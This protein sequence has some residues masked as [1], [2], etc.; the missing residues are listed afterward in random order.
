VQPVVFA[1]VLLGGAPDRGLRGQ[2]GQ[3]QPDPGVA[4]GRLDLRDGGLALAGS[5]ATTITSAPR[6][7]SPVAVALPIPEVAPVTRQVLP[8]IAG[9]VWVT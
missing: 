9:P 8:A 6:R 2:V 3:Q 1:P 7:A 4:G 5:R